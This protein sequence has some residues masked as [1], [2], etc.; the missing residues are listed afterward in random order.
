MV[1]YAPT[2]SSSFYLCSILQ[3]P[4]MNS[5][6]EWKTG[7]EEIKS[8]AD[9]LEAYRKFLIQQN[10]TIKHNHSLLHPV[11]TIAKDATLEH[12]K[13]TP[14]LQDK[15]SLI[16]ASV[17]EAGEGKPVIFDETKHI[18]HSVIHLSQIFKDSDSSRVCNFL[19]RLILSVLVLEVL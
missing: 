11:K 15:Y 8:L 12:R 2:N 13:A 7:A 1:S 5:T 19:Y 6:K 4:I 3:K 10:Q 14:F 17:K 16:N 18:S 9:C